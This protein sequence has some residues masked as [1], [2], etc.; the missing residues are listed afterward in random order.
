MGMNFAEDPLQYG[1]VLQVKV[2]FKMGSFSD[3]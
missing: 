3:T 2:P 1:Y